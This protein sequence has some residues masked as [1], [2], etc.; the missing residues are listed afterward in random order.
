MALQPPPVPAVVSNT[1]ASNPNLKPALIVGL[2]STVRDG[3][4]RKPMNLKKSAV[5]SVGQYAYLMTLAPMLRA[6][7]ATMTGETM[8]SKLLAD[9]VGLSAMLMLADK[10]GITNVGADDQGGV[11]NMG[12]SFLGNI[13]E[14][15]ELQ[16]ESALVTYGLSAAGY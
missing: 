6:Q 13:A 14:G 12:G 2:T 11:V 3:V 9:S 4:M 1:F 15:L 5:L 16:V 7:L 10:T 8:Y